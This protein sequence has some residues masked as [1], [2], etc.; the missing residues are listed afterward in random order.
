MECG[1]MWYVRN[2]K[3]GCSA[4][5]YSVMHNVADMVRF[6]TDMVLQSG[7]VCCERCWCDMKCAIWRLR[8]D[9]VTWNVVW[10]RITS[11]MVFDVE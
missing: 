9:G 6:E 5:R 11:E 10:L 3:M 4:R 8:T 1:V 2:V 7:I